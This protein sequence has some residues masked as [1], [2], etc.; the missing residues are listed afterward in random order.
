M[1]A[2]IYKTLDEAKKEADR[3]AK[4]AKRN[5]EKNQKRYVLKSTEGF[6]VTQFKPDSIKAEYTTA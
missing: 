3:Q 5:Y 1:T 4:E 2:G 6:I